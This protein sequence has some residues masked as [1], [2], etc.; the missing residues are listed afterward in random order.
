MILSL[1]LLYRHSA[2]TVRTRNNDTV[3]VFVIY[4]ETD[5]KSW[6]ILYCILTINNSE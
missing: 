4:Q 1:F 3:V 2:F 6:H 5:S